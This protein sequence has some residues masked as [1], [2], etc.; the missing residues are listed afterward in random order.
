MSERGLIGAK[1]ALIWVGLGIG[2]S[3]VSTPAHAAENKNHLKTHEYFRALALEDEQKHPGPAERFEQLY[4]RWSWLFGCGAGAGRNSIF[5]ISPATAQRADGDSA[6]LVEWAKAQGLDWSS[7]SM[8]GTW[9]TAWH[10]D[11]WVTTPGAWNPA[12]CNRVAQEL[13]AG[14]DELAK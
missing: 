7:L 8:G 1:F 2:S 3:L 10:D 9:M 14:V 12:S 6:R 13:H 11:T 4:N 5:L